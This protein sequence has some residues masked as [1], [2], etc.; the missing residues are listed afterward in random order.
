[1]PIFRISQAERWHR[2]YKVEAETRDEAVKK[3]EEWLDQGLH[4]DDVDDTADPEYLEDL[5]GDFEVLPQ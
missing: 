4:L 1:M 5:E 2:I 3:Y